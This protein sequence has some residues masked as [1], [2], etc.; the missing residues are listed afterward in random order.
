[1]LSTFKNELIGVFREVDL[2]IESQNGIA[3]EQGSL[4]IPK[5]VVQIAGQTALILAELPFPVTAS[6]DLDVVSTLNYSVSKKL[7]ELL[8]EKGLRLETDGHLIWM[9]KET[10]YTTIADFSNVEVQMA[11]SEFIV[12]SKFKFKR[13]KD[14]KLIKAYLE[15]FPDSKEE[16]KKLSGK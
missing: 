3:T 7:S 6:M 10:Q 13:P 1:M 15:H 16:I 8:I 5:Q 12:A 11:K 4:I 9:P 14:E 2:F